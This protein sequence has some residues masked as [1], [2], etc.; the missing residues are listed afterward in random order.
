M[1]AAL[2]IMNQELLAVI[3]RESISLFVLLLVL[4]GSYRLL[5]R[6]IDVFDT[7]LGIIEGSISKAVELLEDYT[8]NRH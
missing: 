1:S 2:Y 7:H 4:I 6:L 5:S 3:A 8:N